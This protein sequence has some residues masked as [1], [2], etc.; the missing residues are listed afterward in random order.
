MASSDSDKAAIRLEV[1]RF[2]SRCDSNES[3]LQR[4]D[5]LREVVRLV[6]LS[7]PFR[8]SNEYEARDAHRRLVLSAEERAKELIMDQIAALI[9]ADESQRQSVKNRIADDWSNLTG[10]LGHLRRWAMAKMAGADRPEAGI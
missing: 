10:T 3:L 7:I 5:S 2:A 6:G 1:R 4:A 8:I 9:R